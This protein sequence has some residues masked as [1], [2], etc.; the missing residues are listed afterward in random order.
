VEARKSDFVQDNTS[1]LRRGTEENLK[2]LSGNRRCFV[3]DARWVPH[4]VLFLSFKY[5][6]GC[7][8]VGAIFVVRLSVTNRGHGKQV[9]DFV[10]QILTSLNLGAR[11]TCTAQTATDVQLKQLQ[12][13]SSNNCRCTAETSTDVQLKQ[14]QMNSSNSCRCTAQ[15]SADVQLNNCRCTVQTAPDVQLKQLQMYSSNNCRCTAQQL[16]MYS[17]NNCR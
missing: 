1:H 8:S 15:T 9:Y 12:M 2:N 4:R 14:L 17:S 13:Y 7:N 10:A 3:R 16:Q 5:S 11:C 6:D